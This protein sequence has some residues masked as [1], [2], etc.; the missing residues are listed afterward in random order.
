MVITSMACTIQL[1]N[2]ATPPPQTGAAQT[3]QFATLPSEIPTPQPEIT[4][5][6]LQGGAGP[7]PEGILLDSQDQ[8]GI[9]LYNTAGLPITELK[10]PHDSAFDLG[11]VHMA[12]PV[13]GPIMTPLVFMSWSNN[14]RAVYKNINDS[15]TTIYESINLYQLAGAAGS[16]LIVFT[17]I[18]TP[19]DGS[20][21]LV[22]NVYF[23]RVSTLNPSSTPVIVNNEGEGRAIQPL[24]VR[25]AAGQQGF[26]YTRAAYGIGGDIVFAPR[27]GLFYYDAVA[28]S[29]SQILGNDRDPVGISPDLVWTAST[30]VA[31]F[32]D[33][34][35]HI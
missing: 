18:G 6:Q 11:D 33:L 12:G 19:T 5:A 15:I 17:D 2:T 9:K 10:A 20:M 25:D 31:D 29:T 22:N 34:Q 4:E 13:S 32:L 8:Y 14:Q 23:G 7:M 27:N 30:R 26:Y 28:N 1:A 21:G 3:Q 16:D 24:A 35:L